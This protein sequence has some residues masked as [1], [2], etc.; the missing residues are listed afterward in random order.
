MRSRRSLR[1]IVGI[2]VLLGITASLSAQDAPKPVYLESFRKGTMRVIESS[3]D[4]TLDAQNP[5]SRTRV[6][7]TA[8]RE[9]YALTMEPQVA[10]PDDP[11]FVSWHAALADSRHQMYKNVL[12]PSLDPLQDKLQVWW[13]NPSPY[14]AVGFRAQRVIKVD[15][16]YC[17][18]QV[19]DF[20]LATPAG[21]WLASITVHVR[22]VNQNPLNPGVEKN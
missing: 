8:R 2:A 9:R 15:N 5:H 13:L 4:V 14:A 20:K 6:L 22:F 11:R 18:L 1:V 21:P 3:F 12:V 16:F 17:S 10:G 19:T 7:D